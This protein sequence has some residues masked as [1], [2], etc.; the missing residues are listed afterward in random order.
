M[1]RLWKLV[2]HYY[3]F[4]VA[5]VAAV[6]ALP[7]ELTGNH[8]AAHILLGVVI[9]AELLPFFKELYRDVRAGKYGVDILAAVAVLSSLALREFW[10]GIVIVLMLTGGRALEDYAEHRAE[11][12]LDALL[13]RA[14]QKARI[15]RGRKE[16]EVKA[17]EVH[18]GDKL[19]I[20][21]GELVAADAEI[22]EGSATFDE[23]SLTGESLPQAKD[24]GAVLLSGSINLDG[25]VTARAIHSAEDSQYQQIIKLVESARNSQAPFVRLADRYAVPF[26]VVAFVIAFT[27]W[28]ISGS[29]IRFL[30]VI[31]VATPCP[32]LLAVPIAVISGMSSAAKQGIIIKTGK[33]LELLANA[34]TFAF[35]K[36]GTLTRGILK[37]EKVT[38]FGRTSRTTLLGISASLEQHSGHAQAAA[39]LAKAEAEHA[40]LL[41]VREVREIAGKG[42]TAVAKGQHIVLGRLQLLEEHSVSLPK[43]F[44][45]KAY[46]Q[47]AAFVAINGDLAGVITFA[48]E[49]RAESKQTLAALREAGVREFLMITG[50]NPTTAKAVAKKLG[51][52][53]V[54]ADALPGDKIH[55]IEQVAHRPVAFVGDGVNDAP[56]LT[57]SDVGIALGARGAAAASESADVVIMQD[58]LGRVVQGVRIA[59]RTFGIAKQ[60]VLA[61]IGLSV[62]LMFVFSTGKFMPIYGAVL[63]EV[64]D[65]IVI[66]NALRA[67]L[68]S[69]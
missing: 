57:A 64:V 43:G 67:H 10:T 8:L 1:N 21:A 50:D 12:E 30:E 60:S 31:V 61:G 13:S 3:L 68:N 23:S 19:I 14:P 35:D 33:S 44:N 4:V 34:K 11:R 18:K 55:A 39:I 20:R 7:L 24:P 65:V 54:M 48:D 26:T 42:I 37:V 47:T 66:F 52:E 16:V 40:K 9:G 38:T 17:S 15:L 36:T 32:L 62:A 22:L 29:A 41:N 2:Q 25:P 6:I 27:A 49:V 58:D 59:R 28:A 56:V 46:D 5:L 69:E 45:P 53:S 51:I 63:Q